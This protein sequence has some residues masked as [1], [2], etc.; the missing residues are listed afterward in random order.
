MNKSDLEIKNG[1]VIKY[2]G[3]AKSVTIPDGVTSIGYCA[4]SNGKNLKKINIPNSVTY[5]AS[6]AFIYCENLKSKQANYKAVT[7][8]KDCTL[9]CKGYK[10]LPNEW[11]KE[12]NPILCKRGYHYCTNLFDIFNYYSGRLNEDIAIF[13]CEVGDIVL[14]SDNN[15]KCCTNTI[16]LVHRLSNEKIIELLNTNSR[17]SE[18][19]IS[20][21]I[22][23][24][25]ACSLLCGL[26]LGYSC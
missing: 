23:T 3:Y 26:V 14:Q 2:T 22:T 21:I 19:S 9:W 1:R 18:I 5:V 8:Q 6:G 7:I 24:I 17:D 25:L 12:E 15:S 4:F 20:K 16:K 13:E 10:F 11:S